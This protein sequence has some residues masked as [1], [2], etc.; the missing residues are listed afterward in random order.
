TSQR[1]EMLR[2]VRDEE[3]TYLASL[4]QCERMRIG[5]PDQWSPKDTLAHI[6]E[7][8]AIMAQRLRA[9]RQGQEA[10]AYSDLDAKNAEIFQATHAHSDAEL[11]AML[12]RSAD[13]VLT[14]THL[15]TDEKLLPSARSAWQGGRLLLIRIPFNAFV[16][17]LFHLAQL[18]AERGDRLAG[19]RLIESMTSGM[20][21]LDEAPDSQARWVYTRACY[22]AL[23]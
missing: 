11:A 6:A 8:N 21:A 20:F 9:Y 19:D 2:R 3:E 23:V 7:W 17:S 14:D 1:V 5:R 4:T 18:Y 13:D 16:H 22:Y 12:Q 10:P 15:C